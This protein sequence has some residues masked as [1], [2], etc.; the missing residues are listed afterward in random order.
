MTQAA[1]E[2]F[3]AERLAFRPP[4]KMTVTE[5]ADERRILPTGYSRMPG[6]WSTDVTPYLAGPMN[7]YGNIH[8]RHIVLCFGT[9]LGKS[10]V[11]FNILLY[12]IDLDPYATLFVY[13][14]EEDAKSIGRGRLR[15]TMLAS[16]SIRD[17][18]PRSKEQFQIMEM[19]F[20]QMPLY[21]V[22][23]NSAAA[24]A[25]KPC[26]NVLRDE[27]DKYPSS[28]GDDTDPLSLS[29]ERTKSYYDIRKIVDVSSPTIEGWGIWKQL[30]NCDVTMRYHVA[31]PHCD[32]YQTL[33][34]PQIKW[35]KPPQGDNYEKE[36]VGV[37][38]QTARYECE[39][40]QKAISD[41]HKPAMLAEGQWRPDKETSFDPEAVAFHLSSLYSPWLTWGDVVEKFL[42]SKE[43]ADL[44][45]FINGWLAE[46]W[47]QGYVKMDHDQILEARTDL[48]PL[49]VPEDA[50]ALTAG[51]DRQMRGFYFV[52]RAWARDL[53]SWLIDYGHL[54][55]WGEVEAMLF[56]TA[57]PIQNSKENMQMPIWRAGIDTGGTLLD[58]ATGIS[59]TEDT[60]DWLRRNG[61]G[62]GCLV[63]GT[64]GS[65]TTLAGKLRKTILDKM[66]SGKP[67]PGGIAL[68]FLDT[69]KLKDAYH[70]RLNEAREE[71][72]CGAYLHAET[73]KQYSDQIL[74]EE[75][76][77]D[78]KGK[79]QWV[80]IGR[81]ANHYLDCE[82]IAMA[83][84]DPEWGGGIRLL[85]GPTR[86][87]AHEARRADELDR[88]SKVWKRKREFRRPGWL[89][90]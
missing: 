32:V 44:Q 7:A 27:I 86:R 20:P 28:I 34:F 73:T 2:W 15:Q 36:K 4:P 76:R 75:K 45:A 18:I 5:W 62:R 22:G 65:S 41:D 84:A 60:Y 8:I 40:C 87:E 13:P 35:D 68:I 80:Q 42:K 11:I 33:K 81:R 49:T 88:P 39:G 58:D 19:H 31:C 38:K 14:R 70:W 74:A 85:A 3:P 69:H 23:A 9:Q 59:S 83:C 78:K 16:K 51:I 67:I 89:D 61:N 66:P 57:Y 56:E 24:L 29:E 48:P 6:Q 47:V 55:S 43:E 46:P 90:R 82:V 17:K 79:E 1:I 37:A 77:K 63:W 71:K 72:R 10:E 64:K 21:M 50:I 25:Q 53:T 54:A 26:R 12:I 52:V 30:E